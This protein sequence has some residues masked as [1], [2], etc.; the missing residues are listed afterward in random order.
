MIGQEGYD[1]QK[2]IEL[3]G[4]D[5]EGLIITTSLD[6]VSTNL[7][8]QAFIKGIEEEAGY[9]EDMVTA[10]THTAVLVI[11]EALEKAGASDGAA[12]R[13]QSPNPTLTQPQAT[14][15][16]ICSGR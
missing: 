9:P 15:R 8:T 10:S 6:L 13:R 1:S 11:A 7:A 2:F 14:S 16:S 4:L 3:A 5:V 12:L